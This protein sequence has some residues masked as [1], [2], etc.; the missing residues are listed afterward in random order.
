[1]SGGD[2]ER[3]RG[4][5][6]LRV[7]LAPSEIEAA[8]LTGAIAAVVDVLRA[9]SVLPV[10]LAAGAR[11]AIPLA[12]ID[13]A[14][15]LR[16]EPAWASALLCGERGGDRVPGFDLGNSP[17]EYAASRVAGRDLLYV[18]TNGA[19]ALVRAAR[20]RSRIAASFVN[21]G[22]AVG[23]LAAAPGDVVLIAAGSEGRVSL[24]DTACCGL[25]AA[26]LGAARADLVA[27]DGARLAQTVWRRWEGDLP[28]LLRAAEHG[29][30][31]RS[32]GF[33]ADLEFCARLDVL[34]TVPVYSDG[35]L[36]AREP[37]PGGPDQASR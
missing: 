4:S 20:A 19:P 18:S 32:L 5:P 24:E 34:T 10:A 30:T 35:A 27:D 21:A 33:G 11:R 36:V 31:L 8:P 15:A 14:F 23:V 7:L 1:M 2:R 22:A 26:R 29:E 13:E 28:G 17:F 37:A 25:L 16:A 12:S 3:G 9:T 6:R